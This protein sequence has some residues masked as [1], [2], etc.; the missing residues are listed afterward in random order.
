MNLPRL[1]LNLNHLEKTSIHVL[2]SQI[3]SHS[4][5]VVVVCR[6]V[7]SSRGVSIFVV[8]LRAA[9]A[10]L[11]TVHPVRTD[12]NGA[13]LGTAG[14]STGRKPRE[15]THDVREYQLISHSQRT[16]PACRDVFIKMEDLML[17]VV[18]IR[19]V[20]TTTVETGV[21]VGTVAGSFMYE[22]N[23]FTSQS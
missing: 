18:V 4:R 2:T 10:I 15:A 8:L 3:T 14:V 21:M 22:R 12:I 9:T 13:M 17:P 6:S 1:R 11:E 16:L 7:L 5:R 20:R 23:F 19:S